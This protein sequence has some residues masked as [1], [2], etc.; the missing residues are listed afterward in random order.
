MLTKI[1]ERIGRVG[2]LT[3]LFDGWPVVDLAP[4]LCLSLIKLLVAPGSS[5]AVWPN[6]CLRTLLGSLANFL[7]CNSLLNLSLKLDGWYVSSW[8]TASLV[9]LAR[10]SNSSHVGWWDIWEYFRSSPLNNRIIT[11]NRSHERPNHDHS[12]PSH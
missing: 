12:F 3:S 7:S 5:I 2:I 6:F 4:P 11:D 10:G 8:L 9:K 1:Y